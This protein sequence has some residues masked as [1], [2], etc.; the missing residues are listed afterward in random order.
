MS[1]DGEAS[2]SQGPGGSASFLPWHLI[3]SFDPGETDLSDY[4]RRLEFLAGIWPSD[5]LQHLAPRAALMCKG[6]AFQKVLRLDPEKLKVKSPDGVKLIVTTLGGVWGKTVLENKYE[7]FE[8][9]IYGISQRQDESNDSYLARHEILFEDLISQGAQLSEMRAYIL[10]RNSTLSSEDKKKVLVESKGDLKYDTVTTAIRML[11]AKFFQDVQGNQK[12]SKTKTYDVNYVQELEEEPHF[13]DSS[14]AF[15]LD[16]VDLTE[17]LVDQF[18]QEGDEDALVVQQFEDAMIDTIQ[19]DQEMTAYM[20][21]YVEAR[22]RLTEKTKSRGFWP[23]RAKGSGK[24]GKGKNPFMR[25]RKPLALRIAESECR[26]CGVRGHWKAECPKRFSTTPASVPKAQPVNA[27]ISVTDTCDDEADVFVMESYADMPVPLSHAAQVPQGFGSVV[28][29]HNCC[30]CWGLKDNGDIR[31]SHGMYYNQVKDRMQCLLKSISHPA[32]RWKGPESPLSNPSPMTMPD[33]SVCSGSLQSGSVSSD[34]MMSC[35]SKHVHTEEH[36]ST[37]AEQ[38]SVEPIMFATS[39]TVGILDLGASQTVMGRHQVPE[40]LGNLPAEIRKQVFEKPVP[41]SFRFGNNSTVPCRHAM[42]VPVDKFWIKIAIVDSRTPFLI[43]NNVCRS[44]GAVIDTLAQTIHFKQLGCTLPLSLSGKKL[45]LLDV[46][47]LIAQKPPRPVEP[48]ESDASVCDRV[49]VCQSLDHSNDQNSSCLKDV[50]SE[51]P[52]QTSV[53]VENQHA[54]SRPDVSDVPPCLH[55]QPV[56]AKDIHLHPDPSPSL[57]SVRVSRSHVHE[58]AGRSIRSGEAEDRPSREDSGAQSDELCPAVPD[59]DQVWRSQDRQDVWGS[60]AERPSILPMVPEEVC[61]EREARAHGVRP[62]PGSLR[63]ATGIDD[64]EGRTRSSQDAS[65]QSQGQECSNAVVHRRIHD[66]VCDRSGRGR[67]LGGTDRE[68]EVPAGRDPQQPAT[69]STGRCS[70]P[71]DGADPTADMSGVHHG[72]SR[73]ASAIE[74]SLLERCVEEYNAFVKTMN[75]EVCASVSETNPILQEMRVFS[76][77]HGFDPSV[78][79]QPR[80]DVLEVY[81]SSESQ[82][83]QQCLRQGLR[84]KRFCLQDGDLS[85]QSGRFKLYEVLMKHRPRHISGQLL[86]VKHG[87]DGVN[88]MPVVPLP[89]LNR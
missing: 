63:G 86:A 51:N 87:V 89:W 58:T 70:E 5:Q 18:I 62:L 67:S 6:S 31:Q 59:D 26:L 57:T 3:P 82:L 21:A 43:S 56:L 47:D 40:F 76:F 72:I 29:S 20:N 48:R 4:T 71:I 22:K 41:M 61:R 49:L 73:T 85:V 39:S 88:S 24:K 33:D 14:H 17:A 27:M 66:G 53:Q 54:E 83:T 80:L 12:I 55:V 10:L 44:L 42:F 28:H 25:S 45:F 68:P 50:Q 74:T 46:C 13:D 30:V 81:C 8:K 7:K 38:S 16:H 60:S 15:Q 19:N 34:S 78:H 36:E 77:Q 64:G 9:A 32:N 65:S 23:V 35:R 69:R 11:G 52:A 37:A 84:A 2:G 79:N 1:A 75:S